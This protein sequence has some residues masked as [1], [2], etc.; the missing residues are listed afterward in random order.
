MRTTLIALATGFFSTSPL[1]GEIEVRSTAG[2]GKPETDDLAC[3]QLLECGMRPSVALD[4]YI[5][6]E[7]PL[8]RRPLFRRCAPPR[9]KYGAG[10]SPTRGEWS[11]R[12]APHITGIQFAEVA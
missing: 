4:P 2:E 3:G 10:S 7:I 1:V 9:I 11:R 8:L 5:A 12:E 6:R